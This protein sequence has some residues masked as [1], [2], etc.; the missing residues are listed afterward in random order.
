MTERGL[1]QAD[2]AAM[3]GVTQSNV[4]LWLLNDMFPRAD[5]LCALAT[6]LGVGMEFLLT[7]E[8]GAEA[9]GPSFQENAAEIRRLTQ[10]ARAAL[11]ALDEA[12]KKI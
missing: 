2:V 11:A 8:G 5:A 10:E 4:S 3:A 1:T 6:A 12:L 9:Q 7:G